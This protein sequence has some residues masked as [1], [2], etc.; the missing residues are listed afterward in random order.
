MPCSG[1][2][3]CTYIGCNFYPA[4]QLIALLLITLMHF[5]LLREAMSNAAQLEAEE[6]TASLRERPLPA[7]PPFQQLFVSVPVGLALQFLPETCVG[8]PFDAARG[9]HKVS[10]CHFF[11]RSMVEG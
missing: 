4:F 10:A 11:L 7:E 3:A 8:I 6:E 1:V 2:L 9:K 5:S